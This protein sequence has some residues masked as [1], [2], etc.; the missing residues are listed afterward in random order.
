M[1]APCAF[2][3]AALSCV[4]GPLRSPT[5]WLSRPVRR[6][7]VGRSVSAGLFDGGNKTDR[8]VDAMCVDGLPRTAKIGILGGGQLGR[9]LAIAG[10]PMGVRVLSLDPNPDSPAS[11]GGAIAT[12]GSFTNK[13]D[14]VKFVKD[15]D[16]L[17]VEIEHVDVS[18]LRELEAAGVDVQPCS[19]TL[20]IIQDK[21]AQKQHFANAGV[22]LGEFASVADEKELERC[23]ADFGF[24]LMLKSRRNAYDGKGNAVAKT[25]A[26]LTSAVSK[27]G[28]FEKGLYCEQW[29]PFARELAVMVVRSRDGATKA[30][31]VTETK[32]VDN[33]C[34]VTVTP[35]NVT[36][37]VAAAAT[38]AAIVAVQSLEGAGVFGVELFHLRDGTILLNEIAPRPHNSGHYTIEAT[39]CCQVR[40]F[41]TV[42]PGN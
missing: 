2:P 27:L 18:A 28:G 20:A 10:A 21:F 25:A 5:R 23:A 11:L 15:C 14:I 33:V 8:A 30:Y 6:V 29:V 36:T 22:P 40:S 19:K 26:D 31:P 38:E 42:C 24:P 35:A 41:N 1:A 34:D 12:V 9:M 16:V 17:T 32:H 13:E 39:A 37:F 7:R 4:K 3:T